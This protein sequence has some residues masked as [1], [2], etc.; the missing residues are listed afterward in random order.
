MI[1]KALQFMAEVADANNLTL[2]PA[3]DTYYFMDTVVSK[4]PAML[5][6]LG[7]PGRVAPA[8]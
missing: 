6:Q 5:E 4:M 2:D 1:A 3:M 7:S 8:F